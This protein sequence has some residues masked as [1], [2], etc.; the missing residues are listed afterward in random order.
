MCALIAEGKG[1]GK[2]RHING[3]HGFPVRNITYQAGYRVTQI[4]GLE[5]HALD[6]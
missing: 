6:L 4:M 1:S 3:L 5:D 2:M